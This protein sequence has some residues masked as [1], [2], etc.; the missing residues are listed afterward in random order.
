MSET[1]IAQIRR[2]LTGRSAIWLLCPDCGHADRVLAVMASRVL[3][4]RRQCALCHSTLAPLLR[5]APMGAHIP[6]SEAHQGVPAEGED[7]YLHSWVEQDESKGQLRHRLEVFLSRA[8]AR[9]SRSKRAGQNQTSSSRGHGLDVA[10]SGN[11]L[12]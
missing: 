12:S 10:A 1:H 7:A 6:A 5:Q 11:D 4:E 2:E 9:F 8:K 3:R